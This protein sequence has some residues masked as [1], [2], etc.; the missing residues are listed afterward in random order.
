MKLLILAIAVLLTV[1]CTN[2]EEP[3]ATIVKDANVTK[4]KKHYA[5]P[6][7][8]KKHIKL[9]KV[10]DKNF[11][12]NYMYPETKKAKTKAKPINSSDN[13][14]TKTIVKTSTDMTNTEC[15]A[16]IGQ[17]KFNNYSKMYGSTKAALKKCKM[18]KAL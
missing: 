7:A 11:S 14:Q 2:K 4:A 17:D 8:P 5:M 3:K 6:K 10:E 18:L 13:N 15:I 1:G 12:S 16:L 9:K